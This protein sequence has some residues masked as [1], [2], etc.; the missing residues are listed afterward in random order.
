M[1]V[2]DSLARSL[3]GWSELHTASIRHW[4]GG[5]STVSFSRAFM[6]QLATLTLTGSPLASFSA[7]LKFQ[8]VLSTPAR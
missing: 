7:Q 6:P 1:H 8:I 5:G 2:G 3:A 4:Y